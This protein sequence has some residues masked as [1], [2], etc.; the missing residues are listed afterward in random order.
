M[1]QFTHSFILQEGQWLAKGT[2]FDPSG[3]AFPIS[4]SAVIRHEEERWLNQS[5]MKMTSQPSVTFSNCY[6]IEPL[7]AGMETTIWETEHPSLGL[8]IGTLAV[9]GQA[10]ILSYTAQ[11]GHYTGTEILPRSLKNA[12]TIGVSSGRAIKRSPPGKLS[13]NGSKSE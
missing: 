12:I 10:I 5:E 11:G 13:Y 4:G 1:S 9:V 2:L 6:E 7:A 8:V 3:K